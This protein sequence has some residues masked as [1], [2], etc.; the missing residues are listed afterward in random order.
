MDESAPQAWHRWMGFEECGFLAGM[1]EGGVG[2]VF[3]RKALDPS[4][5]AI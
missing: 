5:R 4:G 1:N 3:F 2:E